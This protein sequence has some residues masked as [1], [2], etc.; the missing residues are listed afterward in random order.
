MTSTDLHTCDCYRFVTDP[1]VGEWPQKGSFTGSTE[2]RFPRRATENR[3]RAGT[4]GIEGHT[5]TGRPRNETKER[6]EYNEQHQQ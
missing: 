6:N 4:R 1:V 2:K 3:R 5:Q